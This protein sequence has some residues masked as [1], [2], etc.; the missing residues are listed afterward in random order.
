MLSGVAKIPERTKKSPKRK[1]S[2]PKSIKENGHLGSQLLPQKVSY[3]DICHDSLEK[4]LKQLESENISHCEISLYIKSMEN[5][6]IDR[7]NIEK[8]LPY[9]SKCL[10]SDNQKLLACYYTLR[11]GVISLIKQLNHGQKDKE[12][13]KLILS[14]LRQDIE[15]T[16]AFKKK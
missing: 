3:Q 9:I 5:V 8:I 16:K 1:I 7:E 12:I 4:R 2:T 11:L 15:I 13:K 10:I 14:H 6:I